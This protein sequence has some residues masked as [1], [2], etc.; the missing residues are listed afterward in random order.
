MSGRGNRDGFTQPEQCKSERRMP[1]AK[2]AGAGTTT[3]TI[4][5]SSAAGECAWEWTA[6]KALR[7]ELLIAHQARIPGHQYAGC[8]Q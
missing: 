4:A 1:A 2:P 5:P 7:H 3:L 6:P 8:D